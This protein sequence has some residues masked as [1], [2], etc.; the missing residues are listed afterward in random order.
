MLLS[1]LSVA[2]AGSEPAFR[3]DRLE[4]LAYAPH[5]A[6]HQ[7]AT[8]LRGGEAA[9]R[10]AGQAFMGVDRT[11]VNNFFDFFAP[12]LAAQVSDHVAVLRFRKR[13]VRMRGGGSR[14]EPHSRSYSFTNRSSFYLGKLFWDES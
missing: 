1:D 3:P 11:R 2:I 13:S 5:T 6:A 10:A 12:Y 14:F 9:A 7:G 8:L 4:G